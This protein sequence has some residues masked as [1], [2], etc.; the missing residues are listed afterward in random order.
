MRGCP[1]GLT[2]S[3]LYDPAGHLFLP[4]RGQVEF[5]TCLK[6][7]EKEGNHFGLFS[8]LPEKEKEGGEE[9][10]QKMAS[11]TDPSDLWPHKR[12]HVDSEPAQLGRPA[13]TKK[14][15][16]RVKIYIGERGN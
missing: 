1:L 10:K 3:I 11:N 9:T 7:K 12:L 4:G 13:D 5:H 6:Q 2:R 16:E 8:F 14:T 15:G